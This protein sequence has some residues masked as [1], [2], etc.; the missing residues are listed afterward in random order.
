MS[1]CQP[2]GLWNRGAG[3]PCNVCPNVYTF[4]GLSVAP[5][6]PKQRVGNGLQRFAVRRL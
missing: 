4:F 3:T 6:G 2:M 5:N 1:V